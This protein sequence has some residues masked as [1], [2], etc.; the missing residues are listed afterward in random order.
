[1]IKY[2]KPLKGNKYNSYNFFIYNIWFEP[3]NIKK[4]INK[5]AFKKSK[6]VSN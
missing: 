4:T 6:Q 5:L 1:M 2:N 3:N